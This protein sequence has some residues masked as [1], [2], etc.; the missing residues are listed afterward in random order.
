MGDADLLWKNKN[1]IDNQFCV[2]DFLKRTLRILQNLI[3]D[4]RLD[5]NGY[6]LRELKWE[7]VSFSYWP[8]Y[9]LPDCFCWQ[10][11]QKTNMAP[12]IQR[13][14]FLG[15]ILLL[16]N[17]Y[18]KSSPARIPVKDV[19]D[20]ETSDKS[21]TGNELKNSVDQSRE[22]KAGKS[23]RFFIGS[24]N[25]FNVGLQNKVMLIV[26]VKAHARFNCLR[27]WRRSTTKTRGI[28]GRKRTD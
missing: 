13:L 4:S 21:H 27:C 5:K 26:P 2:E 12:L 6:F 8:I 18:V 16:T 11:M 1:E 14:L 23:W 22:D 10:S 7:D 24:W 25:S 15:I 28:A 3:L 9:W 17:H 20:K 19:K